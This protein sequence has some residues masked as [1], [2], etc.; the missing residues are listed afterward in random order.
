M[1]KGKLKSKRGE[2][3]WGYGPDM[4]QEGNHADLLLKHK[5]LEQQWNLLAREES[6][7]KDRFDVIKDD[8]IGIVR[9]AVALAE[10][11]SCVGSDVYDDSLNIAS[12][13]TALAAYSGSYISMPV[14]P[15]D[16]RNFGRPLLKE[17]LRRQIKGTVV[18]AAMQKTVSVVV[19]RRVKHPVLGKYIKRSTKYLVHDEYGQCEVG[20][21]IIALEGR[22]LSKNKRHSYL[23]TVSHAPRVDATI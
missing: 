16:H 13:W 21:V 17:S 18:K 23:A 19:E 7:L 11:S 2:A 12:K 20:D 14:A 1:T 5:A 3:Y 15:N 8:A 22:P 6:S 10:A 4:F 9:A